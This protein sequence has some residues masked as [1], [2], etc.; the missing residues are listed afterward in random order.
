MG[1]K[2]FQIRNL[3]AGNGSDRVRAGA[4]AEMK[5]GLEELLKKIPKTR[6]GIVGDFCLDIYLVMDMGASDI[7]VETGLA[8]RPVR[9]QRCSLGGAG[10]V[11]ANLATMGAGR[12]KAFGVI[13]DD[14]AGR[15]MALLMDRFGIDRGCLL[16]Q[17]EGW[18]TSAYT[19]LLEDGRE[20]R[21]IDYGNFNQLHTDTS[22]R[23][24][25]ALEESL[26]GLDILVINQQLISGINTPEFCKGIVRLIG[27]HPGF[28]FIVDSRDYCDEY[29][30]A[31]RKL[32]QREG[33]A[34][35]GR[36]GDAESPDARDIAAGLYKRWS[37]PLF[38]TR[39]D[40]GC[41]VQDASGCGEIPALQILRP[42]DTVGAGDS[43]LAGI[44]AGLAAGEDP[45][46]AAE[47]GTFAAGVTVQKLNMTGTASPEEILAIGGNPDFRYR[48][49]LA[50][51]P[52]G[53]RFHPGSEIELVAETREFQFAVF[54]NDGTVSTLRQGWESVM[55]PMMIQCIL[56]ERWREADK[57]IFERV[58]QSV[59]EFIEK[60]TGTQTLVQMKGLAEMVREL[61]R[62]PRKDVLDE[63]GYKQIYNRSLMALVD[64]RM[65]KL[66]K[67]ELVPEDFTVKN[68]IPF[69]HELRQ[70][71][72]I[73]YLASGTDQEDVEREAR[74]L[75]YADLFEGR[76][77]GAVGDV[78]HEPK[79]AAL[80]RIGRDIGKHAGA[81]VAA[82]GDGPVEIRETV[83]QG[84]FGV[85]VASDEVRRF[86]LNQAKRTR[87]IL[88][89]ASLI[90]PDFSQADLLLGLLF[91]GRAKQ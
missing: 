9:E 33:A 80:E 77:F 63:H 87:L 20:D 42:V 21:R 11:A 44:A 40:R 8:T 48:P 53:A 64:G 56:G 83:K 86:G 55:E 69:L 24:L 70:R 30:G 15:Q 14:P 39:G 31:M 22:V 34:L 46:G 35:L 68:S 81:R 51:N 67:G 6:V 54:D 28:P 62:V 16:T 47:L 43:L 7:S 36:A 19:K 32:N 52:R 57:T 73:L 4:P 26:E 12:V 91:P 89:G 90:I 49:D 29:H 60:T 71:G 27:R 1:R 76:I 78:A 88:A 58:Q 59:R 84:G 38:L 2:I 41:L 23:L 82:F 65:D 3:T 10:N 17:R 66:K 74:A 50:F 75:G 37:A 85:G 72:I 45:Q 13:G 61:G 25:S 79:K 18:Q 5:N